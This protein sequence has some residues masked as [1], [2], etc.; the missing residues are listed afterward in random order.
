MHKY[1]YKDTFIHS[2]ILK[3]IHTNRN[4]NAYMNTYTFTYI[5]MQMSINSYAPSDNQNKYQ[6]LITS[7]EFIYRTM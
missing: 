4:R 6:N 1:I 3:H 7:D 2:N 5:H